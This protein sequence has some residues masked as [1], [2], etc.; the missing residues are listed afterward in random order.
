LWLQIFKLFFS[1]HYQVKMNKLNDMT[2]YDQNTITSEELVNGINLM[3]PRVFSQRSFRDDPGNSVVYA[4]PKAPGLRLGDL[5]D[6]FGKTCLRVTQTNITGSHS[7]SY[8]GRGYSI[9]V[10]GSGQIASED[11][12]AKICAGDMFIALNNYHLEADND[13]ISIVSLEI[14]SS[15][16]KGDSFMAGKVL[17][18][19]AAPFCSPLPDLAQFMKGYGVTKYTSPSV[20]VL[21]LARLAEVEPENLLVAVNSVHITGDTPLDEELH[22]HRSSIFAIIY[23]GEGTLMEPNGIRIAAKAGDG[24]IVPIG[25]KHYFEAPN[26]HMSYCGIEFGKN[27]TDYQKH[28][29]DD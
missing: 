19:L 18:A 2:Q 23:S 15:C 5:V 13:G 10:Q 14:G 11:L 26:G 12:D 7:E 22:H 16:G 29:H 3:L 8:S 17:H 20:P 4:A 25:T 21:E 27:G 24:I 9:V 28:F 1:H 6:D